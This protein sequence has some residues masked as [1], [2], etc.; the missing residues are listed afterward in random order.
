MLELLKNAPAV[1]VL[2][3]VQ[4][5]IYV[6]VHKTYRAAQFLPGTVVSYIPNT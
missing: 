6:L 5:F 2:D 4:T 3:Y 1:S